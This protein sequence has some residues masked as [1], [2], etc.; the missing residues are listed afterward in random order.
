MKKQI[1][2]QDSR[3][4]I[5]EYELEKARNNWK[6]L[7]SEE[8][9]NDKTDLLLEFEGVEAMNGCSENFNGIDLSTYLAE[10]RNQSVEYAIVLAIKEQVIQDSIL[11][12]G[13]SGCIYAESYF[14]KNENGTS[15]IEFIN[16]WKSQG[17]SICNYHNHPKR[18]A[19]IPSN[20]DIDSFISNFHHNNED[21]EWNDC[22]NKYGI[23]VSK[24][25]SYDD[26]GVVTK[27]DFFSYKQIVEKDPDTLSEMKQVND[28]NILKGR[29]LSEK[30]DVDRYE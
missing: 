26:W 25:F 19:A 4:E 5:Y 17:A 12:R 14:V 15:A 30:Y 29:R 22:V 3:R 23:N 21:N 10:I 2:V 8:Y 20:E 13:E 6:I 16:K 9:A 27:D 18:I 28:K 11:V 1:N 24:D 7:T